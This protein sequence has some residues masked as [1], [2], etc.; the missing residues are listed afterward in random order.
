MFNT[1]EGML[2]RPERNIKCNNEVSQFSASQQ[3]FLKTSK[4]NF[5]V[6][7][8]TRHHNNSDNSNSTSYYYLQS[9]A[10]TA[11]FRCAV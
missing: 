7:K 1:Y 9:N 5:L 3:Q 8:K 10:L 6:K 4:R 2:R 11:A